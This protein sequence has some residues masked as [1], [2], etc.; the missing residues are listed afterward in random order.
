MNQFKTFILMLVLTVLLVLVG[1]VSEEGMGQYI[2]VIC[3]PDE[4][5]HVLV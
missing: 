3:S 2:F 4:F 5:R 1:S